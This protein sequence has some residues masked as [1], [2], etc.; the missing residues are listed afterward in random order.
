M[1]SAGTPQ[2]TFPDTA[3]ATL[4]AGASPCSFSIAGS[5]DVVV[6]PAGVAVASAL[7]SGS[8]YP[9]L[10]FPE[11]TVPLSELAGTWNRMSWARKAPGGFAQPYMVN[12][13]TLAFNTAGVVTGAQECS[14]AADLA[15]GCTTQSP[16]DLAGLAV[17]ADPSGGFTGTGGLSGTRLFAYKNGGNIMA[18]A[19]DPDG[20]LTLF[21]PQSAQSLP[22]VGA[23]KSSW[24]LRSNSAGVLAVSGTTA[25][26]G[27]STSVNTVTAVDTLTSIVTRDSSDEGA[28]AVSQMLRY[29]VPLAGFLKRDGATAVASSIF[30]QVRGMGL[31]AV[32]R[33]GGIA[34]TTPGTGNGFM[35]LSVDRP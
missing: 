19:V 30:L 16:A 18:V 33:L 27:I 35:V 8:R 28:A 20:S 32:S 6:S 34:P 22:T 2:V 31:N 13:G 1:D 23:A 25:M 12:Y 21:T 29:N 4:T 26:P 17:V 9:V 7:E 14:V 24:V 10:L 11:Q 3:A 5:L 15:G